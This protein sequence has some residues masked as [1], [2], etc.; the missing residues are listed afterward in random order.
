MNTE[1]DEIWNEAGEKTSRTFVGW[2][3]SFCLYQGIF[4][5]HVIGWWWLPYLAV[6]I[7]GASLLF[8]LPCQAILFAVTSLIL[9]FRPK[10]EPSPLV[11]GLL[12][13]L[14]MSIFLV[15]MFFF[16]EYNLKII[17]TWVGY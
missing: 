14:V 5:D 12:G 15:A 4:G 9:R 2:F 10:T 8:A 3:C 1:F 16:V 11:A 7:F 6:G 13:T 17:S